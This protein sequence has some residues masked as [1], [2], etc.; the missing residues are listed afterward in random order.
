MCSPEW[1]SKPS[2]DFLILDSDKGAMFPPHN[3]GQTGLDLVNIDQDNDLVSRKE[4]LRE[5]E[6][7]LD[8]LLR[9]A[10]YFCVEDVIQG[11]PHPS[12][13]E[14]PEA[15]D[16][17]DSSL[18][19]LF[20]PGSPDL[21]WGSPLEGS[22]Q[23]ESVQDQTNQGHEGDLISLS[24]PS[25][26]GKGAH[27][28]SERCSHTTSTV[29]VDL[30]SD[31]LPFSSASLLTPQGLGED[32]PQGVTQESPE[33][34]APPTAGNKTPESSPDTF[35]LHT[36]CVSTPLDVSDRA[37]PLLDSEIPGCQ[38]SG[39]LSPIAPP[40]S[41]T[42]PGEQLDSPEEKPESGLLAPAPTTAHL[43]S[44]GTGE[45]ES[46]APCSTVSTPSDEGVLGA[47][48]PSETA[49][50]VGVMD[51]QVSSGHEAMAD[52]G[53]ETK[54]LPLPT[55]SPASPMNFAA[56]PDHTTRP[57]TQ[58]PGPELDSPGSSSP[59]PPE[60]TIGKSRVDRT[61]LSKM[62]AP[63]SLPVVST[64]TQKE[65]SVSPLKAVFDAL[66][67]DGDGFVRIEEFMEFAAAYGADQVS[68]SVCVCVREREKFVVCQRCDVLN[69]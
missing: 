51:R 28:T 22:P 18:S 26:P 43:T 7:N 30:L 27:R 38:V 53:S 29:L 16:A 67:Q 40:S 23:A 65:E 12:V 41:V 25:S 21:P 33:S 66:D 15:E 39:S 13:A 31:E 58:A 14:E 45:C 56:G 50:M 19:W 48:G 59:E 61:T 6:A 2:L 42:C 55:S 3:S 68:V 62:V 11:V 34:G 64:V 46:P 49:C 57:P 44:Q 10:G 8:N 36:D 35:H 47:P 1:T 20:G 32:N 54:E 17:A 24:V 37:L 5:G 69:P 9:S 52:Q 60:W 4:F 63:D